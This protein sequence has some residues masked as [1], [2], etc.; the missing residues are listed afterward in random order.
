MIK[1]MIKVEKDT[2]N[3]N[4]KIEDKMSQLT[5][6]WYFEHASFCPLSVV[7]MLEELHLW[8]SHLGL[9]IKKY[10]FC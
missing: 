8:G 7:N 9:W 4:N 10:K 3:R 6:S 1:Y 2:G 5:L